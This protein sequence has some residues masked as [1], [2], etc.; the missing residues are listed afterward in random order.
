MPE[1]QNQKPE[2]VNL[3]LKTMP[4][5]QKQ[6]KAFWPI[7]IIAALSAVV[8]GLLVWAAY[9]TGLD[10]ELNALLPGSAKELVHRHKK[11]GLEPMTSQASNQTQPTPTPSQKK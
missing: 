10:E 1:N 5:E 7:L 2:I 6:F 11:P 9:N 8:G 3:P 4:V